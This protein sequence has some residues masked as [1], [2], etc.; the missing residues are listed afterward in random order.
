MFFFTFFTLYVTA[1][2]KFTAAAFSP[3]KLSVGVAA[4]TAQMITAMGLVITDI[5]PALSASGA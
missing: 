5:S 3:Y 2:D 4:S 1:P